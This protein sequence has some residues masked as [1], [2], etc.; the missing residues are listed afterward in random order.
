MDSLKSTHPISARVSRPE[1][2][3]E[4]FDRI[5]YDKGAA[6]GRGFVFIY[7]L[8][9]CYRFYSGASVIRMM[10]HFL[11]R[12]VFRKGLTK[13]LNAKWAIKIT[14]PVYNSGIQGQFQTCRQIE[15]PRSGADEFTRF[16]ENETRLTNCQTVVVLWGFSIIEFDLLT[17]ERLYTY[18][19]VSLTYFNFPLSSDR[20]YKNSHHNDLW[21]ALTEQAQK[22]GMMDSSFTIKTIMD[23]WILQPGF[24]VVNV[25]RNYQVDTIIVSQVTY[26]TGQ[27]E[28]T[29]LVRTSI[30]VQVT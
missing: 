15:E 24:P 23:T 17:F 12:Q 9:K 1:E 29:N 30:T 16:W 8:C 28:N 5:S 13:Y 6:T 26:L 2:I 21:A 3:D 14:L 11:T 20:A 22:D 10:D 19:D 25:T 18:R 7:F 27:R 4:L